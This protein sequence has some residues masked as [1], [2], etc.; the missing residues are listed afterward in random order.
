MFE[1]SFPDGAGIHNGTS[2]IFARAGITA[3]VHLPHGPVID[4]PFAAPGDFMRIMK[5][6]HQDYPKA[7]GQRNVVGAVIKVESVDPDRA[8]ELILK[9]S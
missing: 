9:A 1:M 8:K 3:K 5:W 6:R 2:S 7:S 4:L